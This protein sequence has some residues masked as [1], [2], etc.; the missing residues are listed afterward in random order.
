VRTRARA[1]DNQIFVVAVNHVGPEG[2][3]TY[4]GES[5]IADPRGDVVAIAPGDEP[6]ALVAEL[7]FDLI[8][9]QRIQ[10]PILRGFRPEFYRFLNL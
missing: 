5:Q 8:G 4:C 6:A 3:V 7:D 2:S 9:D 1:Q 10:E